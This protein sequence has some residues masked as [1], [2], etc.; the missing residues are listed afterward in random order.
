MKDII[1]VIIVR[2]IQL[3]GFTGVYLI[4]VSLCLPY[5]WLLKLTLVALSVFAMFFLSIKSIKI[6]GRNANKKEGSLK[7]LFLVFLLQIL[8]QACLLGVALEFRC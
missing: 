4:D 5:S 6:Y 3:L 8:V 7:I 1:E 2:L